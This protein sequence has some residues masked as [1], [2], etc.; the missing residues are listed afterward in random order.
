[1]LLEGDL[2]VWNDD[3]GFGFIRV[4]PGQPD[5]FLHISA[6]PPGVR[7][8]AGDRILFSAVAQDGGKGPRAQEALV[9]GRPPDQGAIR[10][11][12]APASRQPRAPPPARRADRPR[13]MRLR[14]MDRSPAVFLVMALAVFCL[15]G[16]VS[17]A[18]VSPIPL[19]LYPAASLVAFLLYAKD[20]Y[21]ALTGAWRISEAALHLTEALGGWPGA[22]VAQRTM[23]HKT[24]KAQY[25]ATYW[26][27]VV[28]HVGFWG[29]WLWS[30]ETILSVLPP[31]ARPPTLEWTGS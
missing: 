24:V 23:R 17:F 15:A 6:L 31:G 11:T 14:S 13:D 29:L 4:G 30:P 21:R 18:M 1:M 26:L 16:A 27:I 9:P 5:V 19:I 3:K 20:K 28:A 22:F 10:R 7:P 8:Q 2:R 12:S 25:Q